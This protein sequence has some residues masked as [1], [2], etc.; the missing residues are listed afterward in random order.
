MKK[1]YPHFPNLCALFLALLVSGINPLQAQT[2]PYAKITGA[3]GNSTFAWGGG[4]SY[5]KGQFLYTPANIS[6]AA[7][8]GMINRLYYMV[9]TTGPSTSHT[10]TNL[11]IKMGQTSNTAFSP[12]TTF[13]QGLTSVLSSASYNLTV[14]AAG[15]W[16][17]V[18]LTSPFYYDNTK[19]LIIEI[20]FDSVDNSSSAL[21]LGTYTGPTVSGQK[22]VATTTT[23][24]TGST[25]TGLQNFGFDISQTAC[26]APPTPGAAAATGVVCPGGAVILSVNGHSSGVGQTFVWESSSALAGPYT[27]FSASSTYFGLTV[28]PTVTT[29]YRAAITCGGQTSHSAP[30]EALVTQPLNGNYT[31]NSALPASATNFTTISSAVTALG[32]GITGPVVLTVAPGSGPYNEQVII[33]PVTG[34]SPSNTVT[35]KGNLAT[36]T[37]AGTTTSERALFK[38][39]GA[40]NIIID[41]F[42]IVPTG[43]LYGYGVQLLN[44]AD[45]NIIRNNVITNTIT[46]SGTGYNGIILNATASGTVTTTGDSKCDNNIIS[47]NK[48]TGGNAGI[49]LTA[50]GATSV[51]NN[52]QVINNEIINF[53]NYGIYINGNNNTL[54]E[55]NDIKR[56]TRNSNLAVF[57]GIYFDD[58]SRNCRVSKNRIH[59]TFDGLPSA[60]TTSV[61]INFVS[62]DA[63]GGNE[64]IISNNLIYGFTGTGLHYGI[65]NNGS[66]Y[67]KYYHNSIHLGN[68]TPGSG[69]SATR[70]FYQVTNSATGIEFKNNIIKVSRE[71]VGDKVGIA[72]AVAASNVVSNNNDIFVSSSTQAYFG[73][74]TVQYPTIADWRAGTGQDAS[75]KSVDPAFVDVTNGNLLPTENSLNDIGAPVGIT[76]DITGASRSATNPDPGAYEFSAGPCN[77]PPTPG[78]A[79]ISSGSALVCSGAT[80]S[81]D[82]ENNTIGAGQTYVWQSS[83]T[84]GTGFT[85]ISTASAS[86]AFTTNPTSTLYYR[87]AVTCGIETRF[88]AQ[89]LVTINPALPGGTYTINPGLPA[90]GSNFQNFSSAISAITCGVTGPTIFNVSAGNYGE[91]LI[92]PEIPNMSAANSI[93]FNG[94]GAILDFISSN[95]GQRGT[96]QL[97]GTDHITF[98][99]FV[100]N[101][102][103]SSG[104]EYGF[105]VH[106]VGDADYN[107]ISNSSINAT[108]NATSTAFAGIV[109]SGTATSA[110]ST[111]NADHNTITNNIITGGY[112]GITLIG[113]TSAL[114]QGNLITG[115]QVKE[116]YSYGIYVTGTDGIL[117]EKND[118]SRPTRAT[119]IAFN[120]IYFTG[121]SINAKISKNKIHDPYGGNPSATATSFGIQL[122]G[123][124]GTAGNENLITNNLIYDFKSNGP[125]NGIYNNN[126]DYSRYYH[127]TISFDD[128]ASTTPASNSTNGFWNGTDVP[129][130][131]LKNN[132]VVITRNDLSLKRNVLLPATT[133]MVSDNNVLYLNTSTGTSNYLVIQGSTNYATLAEWKASNGGAFDQHSKSVNPLFANPAIGDYTPTEPSINNMGANVGVTTDYQ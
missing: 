14:G 132:I 62:A 99:N 18:P 112:Y 84:S 128:Q 93:R 77:A 2:P 13:Y 124:N 122:T 119:V 110:T 69:T 36:I 23:A 115:N 41:S 33:N 45:N 104:T 47:G 15:T 43:A 61:G 133:T 125:I 129:G 52:N 7:P 34:S 27:G 31:I 17:E 79:V 113:N 102:N 74:A 78:N 11:S 85:N 114:S 130:V 72:L 49:A 118:I 53:H 26:L 71:G 28:N 35:F 67:A 42:N 94:N 40:D 127:N 73:V 107:T 120:G 86:S 3:T 108:Q 38:L 16:F 12:A 92:F 10:Y 44:D 39:N 55:G 116:S 9:G 22:L 109:I 76:T 4:S 117:V 90:G 50:D 58:P 80:V 65:Q 63:A 66:D 88:S 29:Y 37:F 48:I 32:C 24:T 98:D 46:S 56:P 106:L 54:I 100:I 1:I 82:L 103:G 5:K 60:S 70:G 30:V 126:S 8:S 59:S 57:Y 97:N 6:P 75:S 19:T 81:F 123:A 89:V 25:N 101:A 105:A 21:G 87:A 91:Q 131:E 51:I 96:I 20:A 111:S 83:A 64:N 68:E 95:T 121:N